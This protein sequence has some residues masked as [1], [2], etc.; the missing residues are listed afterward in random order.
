MGA[1]YQS[2]GTTLIAEND[3]IVNGVETNFTLNYHVP[4][5]GVLYLRV[6]GFDGQAG[7]Y[8]LQTSFT[9]GAASASSNF[10]DIWWGGAAESGW[11]INLSHQSDTLFATLFTYG[12]DRSGLWLVATVTRQP[13][14]TFTGPLLRTVGPAFNAAPWTGITATQVGTMTFTFSANDRATLVY[15]FNGSTVTKSIQ[16]QVFATPVTCSF[17]TAPRTGATNYQDLWWNP[18]ESGWGINFAHQGNTIFA[19][20]FAYGANNRD[21]WLAATMTR[22]ADGSF[23]GD[24]SR[25]TGPQFDT[26]PWTAI[27]VASVGTMRASFAN[28]AAGTLTYTVDGVTV[29]KPIE[30]QV[31]GA[32]QSLCQ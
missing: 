10:S 31:F 9:P 8:G 28:G 16:R 2:N 32:T 18:S 11:G 23:S 6:V 26:M 3:D 24:L 22:Q 1:L 29:T 15:S 19:T 17:T 12:S 20:L 14:G 25:T 30:R 13:N 7:A 4:A 27:G 21:M 5:A